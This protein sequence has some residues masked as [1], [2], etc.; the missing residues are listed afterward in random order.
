MRRFVASR[1]SR[2]RY[3]SA[4]AVS[5]HIDADA[6]S[7]NE[8]LSRLE[9]EVDF[10]R[11]RTRHIPLHFKV[12]QYN[13]LAGY[14]GDNRQPWFLYGVDN[15]DTPIPCSS[16][17]P[18]K[19]KERATTRRQQILEKFYERDPESGRLKN[20]GWPNF[21]KGLL[22]ETEQRQVEVIHD[23]S[24]A[25]EKRKHRV[26]ETIA[27]SDADI[28]S[29]V[30]CDHYDEFVKPELQACGYDSVWKKRPR[31]SS[32]D[33]CCVAWRTCA[34]ERLASAGIDLVDDYEVQLCQRTGRHVPGK[35]IKDRSGMLVL[36]KARG[37]HRPGKVIFVSTHLARNPE[38]PQKDRLRA[39]QLAQLVVGIEKFAEENGSRNAPVILAGDMNGVDLP[40]LR[41]A[42][43]FFDLHHKV[44]PLV[45]QSSL[46]RQQGK[47]SSNK[48]VP[49]ALDC[50]D[51]PTGQTT[52]TTA[53]EMRI[54]A[55]LYQRSVLE[56]VEVPPL[57]RLSPHSPIPNELHPSDHIPIT[58]VFKMKTTLQ[59][60]Q[61]AA[62]WAVSAIVQPE[63]IGA[64]LS[65][66]QLKE[67]FEVMATTIDL[68]GSYSPNAVGKRVL[69]AGSVRTA[70]EHFAG[71][72][73]GDLKGAV[74][75]AM[76]IWDLQMEQN[77]RT[78]VD[79]DFFANCYQKAVLQVRMGRPVRNTLKAAFSCFDT[80][81]TG[82]LTQEELTDAFGKVL[83]P[84][85]T[86]SAV[87]A[88][89]QADTN[90][91][92]VVKMDEFVDQIC[93]VWSRKFEAEVS[94]A[95]RV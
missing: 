3:F 62:A 32:L 51:V 27:S 17:S 34:F 70:L 29:L 30:E 82:T 88:F 23:R 72:G 42:A 44:S 2:S 45:P 60:G 37:N 79:F 10:L 89:Q 20:P 78:A 86:E 35:P 28:I 90:G 76:K 69:T 59:R 66:S 22:S 84:H 15:L 73:I 67:G 36:L 56:L 25:W 14:L 11:N 16:A 33:G 1:S 64:L 6:L 8:R 24:F 71:A 68:E 57:P 81:D 21:V 4:R 38:A 49:F 94:E 87:N 53:R 47:E 9:R 91:D 12:A 74:T 7:L 52:V 80:D 63:T 46:E 61:I 41:G 13:L 26:I 18:S 93:E 85:L 43:L 54:D 5:E 95:M 58:A 48:I 83:P 50:A 40:R 19:E 31:E 92:G 77:S 65:A 39:R 55:I 75:A